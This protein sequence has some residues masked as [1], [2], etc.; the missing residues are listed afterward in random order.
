MYLGMDFSIS[1]KNVIGIFDRDFM[2][3]VGHFGKY[4]SLNLLSLPA[5]K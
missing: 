1:A 2:E 4:K 5:H 3:Q